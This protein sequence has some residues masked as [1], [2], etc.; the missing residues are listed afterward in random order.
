[1]EIVMA[2]GYVVLFGASY[3][4]TIALFFVLLFVEVRVDAWKMCTLTQRPYPQRVNS[5]GVWVQIIQV[6]CFVGA[7]SNMG[8]I[9]FTT[10]VFDINDTK[11]KWLMFL[12]LEHALLFL[13]VILAVL[14]PDVPTVVSRGLL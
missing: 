10:N 14:I 8:I 12:I 13:K 5:I 3:P 2:F 11:N 7:A 9:I 4:L 1:M 6:M